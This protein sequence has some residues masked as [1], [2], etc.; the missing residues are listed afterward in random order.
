MIN[1]LKQ[2]NEALPQ[3][4]VTI[5][6]YGIFVQIIGVWFCEDKIRYT[7]GLWIGIACAIG[8]AVHLAIVIETAVNLGQ[9]HDRLLKVKSVLRY[10]VVVIVFFVMMKLDLGNLISAFI[11]ILG[12]K[13]AAY[14][15]PIIN[16]IFRK[17]TTEEEKN[18]E[19]K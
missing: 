16:K 4:M 9:G 1:R 5:L 14:M 8:M 6:G 18:K 12:L 19:V 2:L 15:Q 11:G 17:N 7:S 10:L 3:L 13:V